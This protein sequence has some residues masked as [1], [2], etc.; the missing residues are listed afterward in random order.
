MA[1]LYASQSPVG[2][3]DTHRFGVYLW[4]HSQYNVWYHNDEF[5]GWKYGRAAF[6][7]ENTTWL[8]LGLRYDAPTTTMS[9]YVDDLFV[10][11]G[12]VGLGNFVVTLRMKDSTAYGRGPS[13]VQFDNFQFSY[14]PVP[15]PSSLILVITCA[16]SLLGIAGSRGRKRDHLTANLVYLPSSRLTVLRRVNPAPIASAHTLRCHDH[17]FKPTGP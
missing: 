6:E 8:R 16:G 9:A 15:E 12:S 14:P 17:L 5:S 3:P 1:W 11:S 13:T 10:Q 7:D 4:D 2:D